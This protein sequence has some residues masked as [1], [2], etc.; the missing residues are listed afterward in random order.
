MELT[1]NTTAVET[2]KIGRCVINRRDIVPMA[3]NL[4]I[5]EIIVSQ[6]V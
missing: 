1:V 2:V 6:V 3:V 4:V 5:S